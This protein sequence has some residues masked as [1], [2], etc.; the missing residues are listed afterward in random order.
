MCDIP[1]SCHGRN[2]DVIVI[3]SSSS[4]WSSSSGLCLTNTLSPS[5]PLSF[6]ITLQSQLLSSP[7]SVA[8]RRGSLHTHLQNTLFQDRG[9]NGRCRLSRHDNVTDKHAQ[10]ECV[11]GFSIERIC[12]VE[13]FRMYVICLFT[14][15]NACVM[16]M[17]CMWHHATDTWWAPTDSFP[18]RW[19]KH[20]SLKRTCSEEHF[21]IVHW[22]IHRRKTPMIYHDVS[23]VYTQISN[24]PIIYNIIVVISS[25]HNRFQSKWR[26]SISKNLYTPLLHPHQGVAYRYAYYNKQGRPQKTIVFVCA[27]FT[28]DC[29]YILA[30]FTR[31]RNVSACLIRWLIDIFLV[32]YL[33]QKPSVRAFIQSFTFRE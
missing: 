23:R 26:A 25:T 10:I 22:R 20:L 33:T 4:A 32:L 14:D 19:Q 5:T 2:I 3:A 12:P 24:I 1:I 18:F 17:S 29:L 30:V 11:V 31:R 27:V 16:C 9:V 6:K 8:T 7:Q 13:G 15:D 21:H 28:F